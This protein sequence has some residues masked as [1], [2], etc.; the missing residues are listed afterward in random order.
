MTV[1]LVGAGPGD[2]ALLTRAALEALAGADAVV[3]D[4]PSLDEVVAL[5]RPSAERHLVGLAPGRRALAQDEVNALLVEL[6]RSHGAVVRLKSG[7]PF[8]ASRGG[9]EARALAAAGVAVRVTP[10]VSAAL[11]APA[12]AGIPLMLRQLSV[13]VTVVDGNDDPEHGAPPDW[14][15][16][17]RVGGTLVILTGRG[18]IRRIA[19]RLQAGGLAPDTPVAAISAGSRPS[20]RVERGTLAELPPPLPPPVTFVVGAVAALDLTTPAEAAR[21]HP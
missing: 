16:I 20:Q 9:E 14:E 3:Y 17:A 5:A 19:A 18:R 2:P 7:D 12:A 6:G 4:R 13:T 11:A 21:A 15:A 8:V 1:H 10:G